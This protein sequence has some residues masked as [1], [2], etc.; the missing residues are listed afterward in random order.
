MSAA[1]PTIV[2]PA[3]LNSASGIAAPLPA[4]ACTASAC[5][6]P[7]ASFLTVSGV[8]ATRVSPVRISA[9]M[10]MRIDAPLLPE[11]RFDVEA[12]TGAAERG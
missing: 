12:V 11:C 7:V 2:A 5:L 9:G 8:A 6:P 1:A 4:P 10:P 3:A